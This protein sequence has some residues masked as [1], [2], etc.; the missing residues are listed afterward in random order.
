MEIDSKLKP[1]KICGPTIRPEN[2]VG[3]QE[4][5]GYETNA[6][7]CKDMYDLYKKCAGRNGVPNTHLY[8]IRDI[9]VILLTR[10]GVGIRKEEN[11]DL[12]TLKLFPIITMMTAIIINF[13]VL[14]KYH[15]N[16]Y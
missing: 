9:S 7:L 16:K 3:Y 4:G 5:N 14:I 13:F 1:M 15:S 10:I 6:I 2:S 11:Q 8:M 12:D